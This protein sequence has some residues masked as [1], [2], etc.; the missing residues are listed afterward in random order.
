MSRGPETW[1]ADGAIYAHFSVISIAREWRISI[2]V[3]WFDLV[4]KKDSVPSSTTASDGVEV[5]PICTA[6]YLT[7]WWILFR[8]C[9]SGEFFVCSFQRMVGS[10]SSFS[11]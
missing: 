2:F 1:F 10:F 6:C 4:K 9:W 11:V 5:E 8:H 7:Q 3:K